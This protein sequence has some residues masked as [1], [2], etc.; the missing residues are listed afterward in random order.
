M[1]SE[2][3]VSRALRFMDTLIKLLRAR[4]HDVIVRHDGTFAIVFGEQLPIKFKERAKIIYE[5]DD[6]GWKHHKYYP[7]G[8]LAFVHDNRPYKQKEWADGKKPVE[9]RLAEILA[10]LEIYAQ[11]EIEERIEWEKHR[12]IEAE[13]RERQQEIK[14]KKDNEI[15]RIKMLINSANYWKQAQ[16]LREYIKA[17]EASNQDDKHSKEWILWAKLKIE[18][19][20]PFT[21]G[22][23]EI[24]DD[25]DRKLL[26]EELNKK[27]SKSRFY[28]YG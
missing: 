7:S 20:D 16:I 26:M 10:Y 6:H 23:D 24:L 15:G 13:E 19:F 9:S 17:I 22:P 11:K 28:W 25:N 27:E 21:Q 1:V 2:P 12:K 4:K 14:R 5:I 3:N 8:K 18:W